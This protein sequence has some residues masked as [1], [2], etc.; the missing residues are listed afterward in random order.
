VPGKTYELQAGPL[1]GP[2][3]AW[4]AVPFQL[5]S[6]NAPAVSYLRGDGYLNWLSVPLGTNTFTG[7]RLRVR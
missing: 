2:L 4:Q 5:N 7:F 1:P 6:T 3:P